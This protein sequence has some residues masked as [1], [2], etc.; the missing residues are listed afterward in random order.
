MRRRPIGALIGFLMIVLGVL[1]VFAMVLPPG[2]WWF[3]LGLSCIAA[4]FF[5]CRRRW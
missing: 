1:I 2:F 3:I 5:C 4:G